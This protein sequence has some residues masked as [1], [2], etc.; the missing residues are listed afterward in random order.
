MS[1]S[2]GGI[3][4]PAIRWCGTEGDYN[5]L[6]MELLGPSLEDLFNFCGRR[7]KL[8]TV[9]LLADQLVRAPPASVLLC[10][11]APVLRFS[12]LTSNASVLPFSSGLLA[13]FTV[14]TVYF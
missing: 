13:S 12:A 5:V 10:S 4:I 14:C 2:A 1:C 7:F 11:S 8:K 3:G 6:V 9:L